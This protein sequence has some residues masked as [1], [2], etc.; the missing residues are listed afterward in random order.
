M[1]LV[2][3]CN[4][5]KDSTRATKIDIDPTSLEYYSAT[6]GYNF[7]DAENLNRL[8]F[9]LADIKSTEEVYNTLRESV[10]FENKNR[11]IVLKDKFADWEKDRRPRISI[12]F[13][14]GYKGMRNP[15]YFTFEQ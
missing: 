7:D 14:N 4:T 12:M 2:L 6:E 3:F 13:L 1:K 10:R 8:S 11:W 5:F 15:P 9:V